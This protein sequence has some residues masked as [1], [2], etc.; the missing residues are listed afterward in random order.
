MNKII[1]ILTVLLTLSS[2]HLYTVAQSV[3]VQFA[4]NETTSDCDN[5]N[6]CVNIQV[7]ST[8]GANLIGTSSIRFTYDDTVIGFAGTSSA[9]VTQGSYT[10]I[11][12]DAD[13]GTL[14][15]ECTTAMGGPGGTSYQVHGFDGSQTGDFLI[16][17]VKPGNLTASCPDIATD[18]EDVSTICF[19]ILNPTGNPN[20]QFQGVQNGF[21]NTTADTNFNPENNAPASKYDNGTFTNMTTAIDV[22]CGACDHNIPIVTGWNIISSYCDPTT[23]NMLTLFTP[24]ASDVTIV[25]DQLGLTC[26]PQFGINN[27]GNWTVTEGYQ[28]RANTAT[29]L[30]MLGTTID[31][32]TTPVP[33]LTGWNIIGYLRD[34]PQNANTSW[35]SVPGVTLA[36]DYLGLTY[37]PSFSINNIGN[38]TPCQGYQ[39]RVSG[40]TNFTYPKPNE[41]NSVVFHTSTETPS[42]FAKELILT[43]NNGVLVIPDPMNPDILS[44]GD[45]VGIFSED[46]VLM[47]SAVYEDYHTAITFW[48]NDNTT[49]EIDGLLEGENYTVKVWHQASNEIEVPEM[50]FTVGT[51]VYE[52][53]GY[54][55][56]DIYQ[57]TTDLATVSQLAEVTAYP[58][59][60]S[61]ELILKIKTLSPGPA[62]IQL[63]N[64]EGKMIDEMR[65]DNLSAGLHFFKYD[66]TSLAAGMYLAKVVK[67]NTIQTD[68]FTVI[69]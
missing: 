27:I 9:S 42:Y 23:P 59:P 69:K 39:M 22:L 55:I 37:I 32:T 43:G 15:P 28:V 7:R 51:N 38:L 64:M 29:T 66:V 57:K 65:H 44:Y 53:D 47:G 26:I 33:L 31:Q 68:K 12:F 67:D 50:N 14:N 63:F 6:F 34:T 49:D 18:W 60:A 45:E 19:D 24:I 62:T 8:D 58:N 13:Q 2:L 41:D 4:Y 54:Y 1:K 3:D 16:T 30:P 17:M 36:K 11:N 21:P 61:S 48:G 56:A 52:K 20:L 10:S 25:K 5:N 40:A 46:D 35:A